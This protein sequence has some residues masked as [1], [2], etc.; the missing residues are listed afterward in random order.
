MQV[1]CIKYS[2]K[3]NIGIAEIIRYDLVKTV[4]GRTGKEK[5]VPWF[6]G[7][8]LAEGL[9]VY[10]NSGVKGSKAACLRVLK[11]LENV[12]FTLLKDPDCAK[13]VN[14]IGQDMVSELRNIMFL[15][16]SGQLAK[17]Q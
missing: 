16:D 7:I 9:R 15:E 6:T 17:K 10:K 5:Q 2:E 13:V 8:S 3:C 12:S 4:L 14:S 1:P 11:A